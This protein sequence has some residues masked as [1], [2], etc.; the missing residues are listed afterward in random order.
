MPAGSPEFLSALS[1][2]TDMFPGVAG[3]AINMQSDIGNF[4]LQ[5]RNYKR[6]RKDALADWDRVNAY[7]HPSAIMARLRDAGINPN[8]AFGGIASGGAGSVNSPEASAS[9]LDSTRGRSAPPDV[10]GNLL[11][12]AD[13]KIKAAQANNLN[14][15]TN[16]I[17]EEWNLKR[18]Q[19]ERAGF[20]LGIE[21][22]FAADHRRES[23]RQTRT[24]TDLA[25]AEDA[26]RA[27]LNTSNLQE[28]LERMLTMQTQRVNTVL[29]RSKTYS[30][31]RRNNVEV[32]RA[33]AHIDLMIKDGTLRDIE[34]ELRKQ[35]VNPNDPAYQRELMKLFKSLNFSQ[36]SYPIEN[37]KPSS[38]F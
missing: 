10:M 14:V 35:G 16:V 11:A 29:D 17:R 13:L 25:I 8:L 33:K 4:F 31:I 19:A 24:S 38:K 2:A 22:E 37:F 3:N 20:D 15:Q 32:A 30:E 18:F 28:A 27:S 34:I 7:N 9:E 21:R 26:R 12:Q 23:I 6:N 36:D 5:E 1:G